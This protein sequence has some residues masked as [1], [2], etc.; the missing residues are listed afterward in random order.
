MIKRRINFLW[1]ALLLVSVT[2][3]RKTILGRLFD[4]LDADR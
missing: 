4:L 3:H 2:S 1:L